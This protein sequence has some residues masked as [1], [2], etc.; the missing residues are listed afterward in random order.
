MP[1]DEESQAAP[2]MRRGDWSKDYE[3]VRSRSRLDPPSSVFCAERAKLLLGCY[4]R[5]VAADPDVYVAA[6]TLV[7]TDF[8]KAVVEYATDPRTGIAARDEFKAFP[9]NAGEVKEFCSEE[10]ER[11]RKAAKP[12]PKF[13]KFEYV[14]PE[15]YP[16]C[17]AIQF[18]HADAPQYASIRAWA[19]G[20][21]ADPLHWKEDPKKRPGIWISLMMFDLI[22]FGGRTRFK[23][24]FRT[25]SNEDLLD[26][27]GFHIEENEAP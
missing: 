16:G 13:R 12:A 26:R 19:S 20:P 22:A 2:Q 9:P 6:I 8:P 25:P 15:R 23:Q 17:Y 14:A 1:L 18:V 27:Y 10:V 3:A 11:I 4:R 5:N 21:E 24:P 7:L